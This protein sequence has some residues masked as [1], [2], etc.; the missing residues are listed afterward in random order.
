[1]VQSKPPV[2][3]CP[4]DRRKLV[5]A[6]GSPRRLDL[7]RALGLQFEI[8]ASEASEE[9]AA[10]LDIAEAVVDVALRKARDVAPRH[11]NALVIAADTLVALDAHVLGKP[12]D[13]KEAAEMLRRLSGRSHRVFT[14]LAVLDAS[15]LIYETR[16]MQTE[17]QFRDLSNLEIETYVR[18]GEPLDKAG[19][20]GMQALGSI[21]VSR[22]EGDY[23]NVIG[24]P[25]VALNELLKNAGCCVLCR[26]LYGA[27]QNQSS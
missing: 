27:G 15:T 8:D 10:G 26:R 4:P 22:I 25:L 9:I 16:V 20:Y 6:S 18:S 14:G 21:F 1:M 17:V 19:A 24:L 23:F 13:A 12:R 5:L 11:R 3:H 7:L 2:P